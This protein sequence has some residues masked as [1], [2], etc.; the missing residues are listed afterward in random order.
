MHL[1]GAIIEKIMI[2]LDQ[3]IEGEDRPIDQ[4]IFEPTVYDH[5]VGEL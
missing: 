4:L 5:I 1:Q 2:D 3:T